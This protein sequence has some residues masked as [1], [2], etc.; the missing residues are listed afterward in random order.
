MKNFVGGK[1]RPP[2]STPTTDKKGKGKGKG[3]N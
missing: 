2:R 3:K 1:S